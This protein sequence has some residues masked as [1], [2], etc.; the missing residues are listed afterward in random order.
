MNK[1]TFS[2]LNTATKIKI[3]VE[4]TVF[5]FTLCKLVALQI[6]VFEWF[7]FN[8]SKWLTKNLLFQMWF[9][10]L[11]IFFFKWEVLSKFS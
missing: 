5:F 9:N 7:L 4:N 1:V 10:S 2:Q 11:G 6:E 8:S 3:I